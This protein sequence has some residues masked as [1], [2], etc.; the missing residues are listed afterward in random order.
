MPGRASFRSRGERNLLEEACE[1]KYMKL[2]SAILS[3]GFV[4]I[5]ICNLL[6]LSTAFIPIAL[7]FA[8]R[9]ANENNQCFQG[10]YHYIRTSIAVLVIGT[11][12]AGL[13]IL[14][15]AALSS[16]LIL[17]GLVL[18][19]LTGALVVLRCFSG[20]V[21]SLRNEPHRNEKSYLI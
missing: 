16:L 14:A 6:I 10:H 3:P 19:C 9:F 4:N 18:L 15:G 11:C 2:R 13:M 12:L 5:G 21:L 1:R 8:I 17:A 20:L 7:F